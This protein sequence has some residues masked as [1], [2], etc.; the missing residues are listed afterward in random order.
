MF[1]VKNTGENSGETYKL[2]SDVAIGA[3]VFVLLKS[4]KAALVYLMRHFAES[5]LGKRSTNQLFVV[6]TLPNDCFLVRK[7]RVVDVWGVKAMFLTS[8]HGAA[9]P[10]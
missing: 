1:T 9:W 5:A 10:A 4:D 6:S 2:S 7:C 3:Y 8:S